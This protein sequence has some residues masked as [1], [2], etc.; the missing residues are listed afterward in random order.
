MEK[1]FDAKE[2]IPQNLQSKPREED[3]EVKEDAESD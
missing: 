2:I 1:E 3:S